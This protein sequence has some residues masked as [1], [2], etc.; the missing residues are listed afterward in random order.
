MAKVKEKTL[1]DANAEVEFMIEWLR[2]ELSIKENDSCIHDV[3]ETIKEFGEMKYKQGYKD[4]W[5][6]GV[7]D[8]E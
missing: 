3:R 8:G 7:L 2:M 1:E 4:G 5:N 6:T